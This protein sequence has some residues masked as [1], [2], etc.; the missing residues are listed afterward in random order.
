MKT[1]TTHR[2]FLASIVNTRKLL[3]RTQKNEKDRKA[4]EQTVMLTESF[5]QRMPRNETVAEFVKRYYARIYAMVPARTTED[6]RLKL[7]NTIANG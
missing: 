6:A 2:E 7:L 5:L 1:Y 4:M 3:L